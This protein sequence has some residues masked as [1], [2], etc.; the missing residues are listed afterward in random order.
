MSGNGE[1]GVA[2]G[3]VHDLE[4]ERVPGAAQLATD[5]HIE[6]L[7]ARIDEVDIRLCLRLDN[8][9]HAMGEILRQLGEIAEI[10]SKQER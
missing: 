1:T 2:M 8:Q 7:R 3:A 9:S 10:L 6:S 4:S 5:R